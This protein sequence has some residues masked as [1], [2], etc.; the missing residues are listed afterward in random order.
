MHNRNN[1]EVT[2]LAPGQMVRS[3]R[4]IHSTNGL[5][6]VPSVGRAGHDNLW[7]LTWPNV[8]LRV[9]KKDTVG[10]HLLLTP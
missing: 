7:P 3:A 2:S 5:I 4:L 8:H 10:S 6:F 9:D 1:G